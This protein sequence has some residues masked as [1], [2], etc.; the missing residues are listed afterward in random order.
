MERVRQPAAGFTLVEI[1]VVLVIFSMLM[2]ASLKALIATSEANHKIDLTNRV[3]VKCQAALNGIVAEAAA[4]VRLYGDDAEGQALLGM[5]EGV[6][7]D[8]LAD[9]KLPTLLAS[10]IIEKDT[11]AVPDTGNCL[12]FLKAADPYVLKS[13]TTTDDVLRVDLYQFVAVYLKNKGLG[14]PLE[15][16][17]GLNLILFRSEPLVDRGQVEA[18]GD[19]AERRR[20]LVA[21]QEE[22]GVRLV[23]DTRAAIGSALG[24]VDA[25]GE[26]ELDPPL[27]YELREAPIAG[28]RALL[29]LENLSIATNA[30]PR[31]YGVARFAPR[32]M[33]GY[34]FPHGFEVRIIG[35][36]SARQILA[37]LTLALRSGQEVYY[38]DLDA[39]AVSRDF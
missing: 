16:P 20:L 37:H 32:Q 27:P 26:I 13:S 2:L 1:S 10:G 35:S 6:S 3:Q 22:R 17:D 5:L 39:V 18:V 7:A 28:R 9:S 31:Q 8:I 14:S 29:S 23:I 12:L 19:P 21:L 4:S 36:P 15:R 38:S 11:G 33:T 30:S 25:F 34:G 24:V